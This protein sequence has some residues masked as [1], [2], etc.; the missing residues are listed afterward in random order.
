MSHFDHF[1][2]CFYI[3]YLGILG[4]LGPQFWLIL[5]RRWL[6]FLYPRRRQMVRDGLRWFDGILGI[7]GIVGILENLENLEMLNVWGC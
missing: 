4:I 3:F 7:L 2:T 6:E 1:V 5:G